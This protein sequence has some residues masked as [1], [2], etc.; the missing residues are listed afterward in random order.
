MKKINF[1]NINEVL[2]E[3]TLPNKLKVIYYK[4]KKTK[5]FYIT[6]STLYGAG[7]TKYKKNGKVINVIPGTAHFLEHRIMDFT[8][9]KKAMKL[10]SDLG[11][12]PNAYTMHD[13]TNYN[14][15]GGTDLIKN[16]ELLLDRVFK[17][18]IRE[19][20]V[21]SERGIIG[22][23]IDME[24]DNINTVLLYSAMNN[25][26]KTD[27]SMCIP[28]L[29]E[30]ADI[31]K[32]TSEYLT[33]IYNDFYTYDKM[34]IVVC[35][36]FDI[37]E[38]SNYIHDYFKGTKCSDEKVKVLYDKESDNVEVNYFEIT[39]DVIE[40]KTGVV[41]K[42]PVKD[43]KG[44]KNSD[45]NRYLNILCTCM[46]GSTSTVKSNLEKLGITG[47]NFL[48][49]RVNNYF[50]II[51]IGSGDSNKF[52][53]FILDTIKNIKISKQDFESKIKVMISA[54]IVD[55]ENIVNVEGFITDQLK[56]NGK[57]TNNAKNELLKLD[58]YVFKN[59]YKNLNFDNRSV[60]RI[61][62]SKS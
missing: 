19:E 33:C 28:V 53:N 3:E 51:L 39:R 34:H 29:G 16:L 54:L 9:N 5:N 48:T 59:I 21:I 43:F 56:L 22:E 31:E 26:F 7:V 12:M 13:I 42:I 6:V 44:I 46:Y 60:L 45:L 23:E 1:K 47:F 37:E 17:P 24:Q 18:N 14:I 25:T 11:S 20:D 55:F 4:T 32:I 15:F 27:K 57:I 10:I 2:Y 61:T 58:Y 50:V 49:K 8:K 40:D 36:D 52:V 35:G 62:S 30:K 38:V 41:F